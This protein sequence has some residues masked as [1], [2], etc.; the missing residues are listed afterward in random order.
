MIKKSTY[1]RSFT[2]KQ[3]EMLETL[4]SETKIKTVPELLFYALDIYF[5]QKK[6]IERLKRIID[7]KQKKI[8]KLKD[9]N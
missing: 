3:K 8:E 9:G 7:I 4:Q 6:D 2:D 1:I 5:E